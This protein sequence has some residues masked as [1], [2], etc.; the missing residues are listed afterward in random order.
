MYL[1]G[2]TACFSTSSSRF[3]PIWVVLSQPAGPLLTACS[4]GWARM[5]CGWKCARCCRVCREPGLWV[6]RAPACR[7]SPNPVLRGWTTRWCGWR[8]MFGRPTSAQPG[9]TAEHLH[10]NAIP[11]AQRQQRIKDDTLV[12]NQL[13]DIAAVDDRQCKLHR[14]Q[15]ERTANTK[16]WTGSKG[17]VSVAGQV[18]FGMI[19][20][21]IR[22]KLIWL[23]VV[24][25]IPL[26]DERHPDQQAAF[27]DVV[28][29]NAGVHDRFAWECP[30]RRVQP[31]RLFDDHGIKGQLW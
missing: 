5:V 4:A 17:Y 11:R 12:I 27:F 15:G 26:N 29:V 16:A 3:R 23:I 8:V 31:Q 9:L 18:F 21:A 20:K 6:G 25:S 14:Q 10:E 2:S 1:R 22:H 19:R 7:S 24:A 13:Q 28:L 30:G